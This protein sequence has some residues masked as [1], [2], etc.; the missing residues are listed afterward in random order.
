MTISDDNCWFEDYKNTKMIF[1]TLLRF[2]NEPGVGLVFAQL[3][4]WVN[5]NN[6]SSKV[7]ESFSPP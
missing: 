2:W 4:H 3:V 7:E 5:N 1:S 6:S